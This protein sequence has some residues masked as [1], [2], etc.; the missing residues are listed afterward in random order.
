M[1]GDGDE[2]GKS[3]YSSGRQMKNVFLSSSS[4]GFIN[5]EVK[6]VYKSYTDVRRESAGFFC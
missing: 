2:R 5:K 3:V 6:K 4:C 1:N